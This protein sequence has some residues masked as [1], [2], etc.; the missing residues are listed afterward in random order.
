MNLKHFQLKKKEFE[1]CV[2]KF[3]EELIQDIRKH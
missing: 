1:A 3:H 2:K